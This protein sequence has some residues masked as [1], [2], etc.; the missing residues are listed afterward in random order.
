MATRSFD[1]IAHW[2]GDGA[3]TRPIPLGYQPR[4]ATVIASDGKQYS[5]IEGMASNLALILPAG[6]VSPALGFDPKG[7]LLTLETNQIGVDYY[8][9]FVS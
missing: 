4:S 8:A 3:A 5:R 1:Y 2:T 6:S 7:I 9:I